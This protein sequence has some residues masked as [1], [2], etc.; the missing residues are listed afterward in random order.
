[1][2]IIYTDTAKQELRSFVEDQQ[3]AIERL[4]A[5]RKVVYG[6]QTLE[7]TASDI[8]EAS[9]KIRVASSRRVPMIRLVIQLYGVIGV[10]LMVGAFIYPF[11]RTMLIENRHQAILFLMGALTATA[12]LFLSYFYT[13][14]E[15]END[16]LRSD[17]IA[18]KSFE[19]DFNNHLK[20]RPKRD[21]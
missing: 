6:D 19:D 4:I 1:M 8:K 3:R 20:S 10:G 16:G 18:L 5:E 7:I 11:F 15:R 17:F 21:R 14:R 12:S 13:V 2:K 9:S